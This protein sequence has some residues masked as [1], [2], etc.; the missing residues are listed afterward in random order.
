MRA[1]VKQ[2]VEIH[3]TRFSHQCPICQKICKTRSAL[4]VHKT[5]QHS[6]HNSKINSQ[7][8]QCPICQKI[9]KTRNALRVHKTTQH[10]SKINSQYAKIKGSQKSKS[11]SKLVKEKK[12][13]GPKFP[14]QS[15]EILEN[16]ESFDDSSLLIK[17]END[18]FEENDTTSGVKATA[19]D[20]I[21]IYISKHQFETENAV[22]SFSNLDSNTIDTSS[23]SSN[24][25][26]EK[27]SFLTPQDYLT[28]KTEIDREAELRRSIQAEI[29]MRCFGKVREGFK[30]KKHL[31]FFG[32][33][34]LTKI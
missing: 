3:L 22:S 8:Q 29:E 32:L 30:N 1:V 13:S 31:E 23:S 9:C 21:I 16:F 34:K 12:I 7:P 28:F 26:Q 27:G 17:S 20:P 25:S 14:S 6:I 2:H 11:D 5:E 24:V 4:R 15:K 19:A 33:E 18:N 10:N